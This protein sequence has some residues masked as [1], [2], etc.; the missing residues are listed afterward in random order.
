MTQHVFFLKLNSDKA[1][2][3]SPRP[4]SWPSC[5]LSLWLL[6][7]KLSWY[8]ASIASL[9]FHPHHC[10]LCGEGEK[11]TLFVSAEGHLWQS[12]AWWYWVKDDADRA[13][14]LHSVTE[15]G[16]LAGWSLV[17]LCVCVRAR[18]CVCGG[19]WTEDSSVLCNPSSL[20]TH[21]LPSSAW[22]GYSSSDCGPNYPPQLARNGIK[23]EVWT[24]H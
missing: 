4:V 18:L 21:P 8:S 11:N 15:A 2:N 9:L 22:L 10:T 13:N 7:T 14:I 6:L 20:P 1:G 19:R 16:W 3:R 5:L 12:S 17:W 24:G 23:I